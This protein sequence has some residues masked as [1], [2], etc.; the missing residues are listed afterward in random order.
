MSN[1]GL[2]S[3]ERIISHFV[4][5]CLFS[6]PRLSTGEPN[7]CGKQHPQRGHFQTCLKQEK[8]ENGGAYCV[9]SSCFT[10]FL[11]V[12]QTSQIAA[13]QSA[14]A[15]GRSIWSHTNPSACGV[16]TPPAYPARVYIEAGGGGGGGGEASGSSGIAGGA[17]TVVLRP[18]NTILM[19]AN[20]GNP[21]RTTITE[22]SGQV[23]K[24]HLKRLAFTR[25]VNLLFFPNRRTNLATA[26][27]QTPLCWPGAAVPAARLAWYTCYCFCY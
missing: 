7:A 15:S 13:L 14:V 27:W 24:L 25:S 12:P 1:I 16:F 4:L 8:W 10:Q 6:P 18:N 26:H 2:E 3:D 9:S 5:L 11:T 23:R 22:S 21:G 17:T 20:G 19:T